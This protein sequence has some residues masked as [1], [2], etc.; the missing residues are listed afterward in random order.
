MK[1]LKEN[2][3]KVL[4]QIKKAEAIL[5]LSDFDGTI[6]NIAKTPDGAV[7]VAGG[8]E[9]LAKLSEISVIGIVSGRGLENIKQKV[10]IN[11]L[12][13]AGNHGAEWEINGKK[14]AARFDKKT[15]RA[16]KSAREEFEVL[17]QKYPGVF[18]EEKGFAFSAHYRL[19]P[20]KKQKKFVEEAGIIARKF[21]KTK[22]VSFSPGKK[23]IDA[24]PASSPNKGTFAEFLI[25]KLEKKGKKFLPVF[26]GDDHTDEDA[27]KVLKNGITIHVGKASD[28]SRAKYFAKNPSEVVKF[29][30]KVYNTIVK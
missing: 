25:N 16:I 15:L 12:I 5:L 1:S 21:K 14:G 8:K 24:K 20:L 22:L 7:L 9:I 4:S 27:F 19:A 13:Y 10:S 23:V 26:L 6:S 17:A 18:V 28:R 29:L 30:E 3:D 11:N 2:L